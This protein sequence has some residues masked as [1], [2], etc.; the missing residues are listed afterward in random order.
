MSAGAAIRKAAD[1]IAVELVPAL[2]EGSIDESEYRR[3]FA[4]MAQARVD[5]VMVN[6][7]AENYTNQRSIAKLAESARLPAIYPDR[8]FVTLGGL[9][10][11]GIEVEEL[12]RHIAHQIDQILKGAKPAEIPFYQA[13]QFK[14]TI[15]LNTARA[16][17]LAIP[18]SLVLR[19]DEVIQ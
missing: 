19:A 3:V 5:A 1:Q 18:Q 7:S 16:L 2:L 4:V 8:S 9:M 10:A 12:Y 6:D 13:T 15:N 11:Y 17:G 14:L